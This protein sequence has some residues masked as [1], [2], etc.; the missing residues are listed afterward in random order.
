MIKEKMVFDLPEH[1]PPSVILI[2]YQLSKLH[3]RQRTLTLLF[4]TTTKT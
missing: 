1:R 3:E 4:S 2:I